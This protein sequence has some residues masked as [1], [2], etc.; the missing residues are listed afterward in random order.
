M[1]WNAAR[2]STW[3]KRYADEIA[4][5]AYRFGGEQCLYAPAGAAYYAVSMGVGYNTKKEFQEFWR[6]HLEINDEI[7]LQD[8]I[9]EIER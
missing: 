9:K 3:L 2:A 7:W 6:H 1:A 5:D 8:V 4:G